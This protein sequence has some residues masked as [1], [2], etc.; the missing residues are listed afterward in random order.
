MTFKDTYLFVFVLFI[1]VFW[2]IS[3]EFLHL[4]Q[5][6]MHKVAVFSLDSDSVDELNDFIQIMSQ[7]NCFGHTNMTI[8][9]RLFQFM[10]TN[11]NA[12]F[13]FESKT[14]PMMVGCL[15]DLCHVLEPQY[16]HWIWPFIVRI[17]Q[18]LISVRQKMPSQLR[19]FTIWNWNTRNMSINLTLQKK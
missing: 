3:A 7:N 18:M 5:F 11:E 13:W 16:S 14:R 6:H 9:G 19:T 10:S 2:V 8:D 1:V 15:G 17:S 4:G 12:W